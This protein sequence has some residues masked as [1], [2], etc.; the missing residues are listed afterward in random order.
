[1]AVFSASNITS[2]EFTR[3]LGSEYIGRVT[4]RSLSLILCEI[5]NS[6][7]IALLLMWTDRICLLEDLEV[8]QLRKVIFHSL[9]WRRSATDDAGYGASSSNLVREAVPPQSKPT[10][11]L[12]GAVESLLQMME[13][14]PKLMEE[15][16][17][18]VVE[19]R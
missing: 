1:M 7:T 17:Q 19:N 13:G 18:V 10:A 6:V 2:A 9:L 11:D 14:N 8:D 15:N 5:H 4:A 3:S 12:G 16:L